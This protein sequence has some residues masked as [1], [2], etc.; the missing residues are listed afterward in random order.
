[1]SAE[2]PQTLGAKELATVDDTIYWGKVIGRDM[3]DLLSKQG[4]DT[5]EVTR[6]G[7]ICFDVFYGP[8][9]QAVRPFNPKTLIVTEPYATPFGAYN[10]ANQINKEGVIRRVAQGLNFH[11]YVDQPYYAL[12]KIKENKTPQV[13]LITWLNISPNYLSDT[14]MGLENIRYYLQESREL[15]TDSGRIIFTISEPWWGR[16]FEQIASE[17]VEGL[18][19]E[20]LEIPEASSLL[21][22]H[23]LVAKK[24]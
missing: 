14:S 5:V 17:G 3:F 24:V 16:F 15:I 4:F 18:S 20:K 7:A 1:M 22:R 23:C 21:G 12:Q 19:L 11:L 8:E 13:G 2:N 6:F 9:I 10:G